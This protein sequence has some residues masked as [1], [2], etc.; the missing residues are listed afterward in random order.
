MKYTLIIVVLIFPMISYAWSFFDMGSEGKVYKNDR[1]HNQVVTEVS[2]LEYTPTISFNSTDK[3]VVKEKSLAPGVMLEYAREM[4]IS[5]GFSWTL[6]L[7]GFF[8]QETKDQVKKASSALDEIVLSL[9]RDSQIFGG[10]LGLKINYQIELSSVVLQPFV[11]FAYGLGNANTKIAYSYDLGPS[12]IQESYKGEVQDEFNYLKYGIGV[13][14]IASSGIFSYFSVYQN[15]FTTT[16]RTEK[17]TALENGGSTTSID[18]DKKLSAAAEYLSFN[19][20]VGYRF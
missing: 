18:L 10:Q 19:L 13:N 14:I 6:G 16:K 3:E 20:G 11:G 7:G 2:A 5:N 4:R 8:N 15:N 17:A 9:K 12:S 1:G